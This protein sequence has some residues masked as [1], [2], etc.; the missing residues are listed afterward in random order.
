[1]VTTKKIPYLFK[2]NSA[3]DYLKAALETAK[4][5]KRYEVI[6][7][8]GK[9]WKIFPEGQNGITEGAVVDK[10][11]FYSGSSGIGFFFLRLYQ[12]TKDKN[13]LYEAESAA[14]YFIAH[15]TGLE[16]YKDIQKKI[17]EDRGSVYGWAFGYKIGPIS[18]GQ[19]AYALYRETKK[20]KYRD[21]AI[22]VTNTFVEAGIEDE[23][24]IHWS[25]ARDIVGDAGGIVYLLQ[26]YKETGDGNYLETA[27]KAGEYIRH[28]AHQAAKGGTY[29]D[30][31][32]LKAAGEGEE[33]AVHVNFS[34]GSAGIAYL[35]AVLYEA[36]GDE[37]YRKLADDIIDYLDGIS[38]GDDTAVLFPYQ[39]HPKK[40]ATYDKFYLGMC[41]GPIGSSF[42]FKKL[43][44]ITGDEKYLAWVRRLANGLVK[45][46]VPEKKSWGYW[47]SRCI[48]C[49]GPGVLEYFAMLYDFTKDETYKNYANRTADI[50]VSESYV[51]ENGRR[52]YGAWDREDPAR[53]VSYLGFYIGASG[54]AGALLRWYASLTDKKTADFFE[55]IL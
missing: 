35:W 6:E 34:H 48:C 39:D 49:G 12:V 14:E 13:W 4:W 28:F 20:E 27:I 43:Y 32:D 31:Y 51:Q 18:E 41:G 17:S 42:P 2:K 45:A 1:M 38:V 23:W 37:K 5:I 53:V 46:G 15:E 7:D 50:L 52:W 21:Y 26:M 47:G 19:F 24:G 9:T 40:G 36:T 54:A 33:G 44:E 25:D 29:Y 8:V 22:R 16:F 3:E 55:Y 30:L 11:N 10:R